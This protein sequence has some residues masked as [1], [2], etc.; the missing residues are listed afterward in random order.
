MF[1]LNILVTLK[2]NKT[3]RTGGGETAV[4]EVKIHSPKQPKNNQ[5]IFLY[6]V[7]NEWSYLD[8]GEPEVILMQSCH[9][10]TAEQTKAH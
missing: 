5:N 3:E 9:V 1:P 8:I 7:Y 2:T 10:N 6:F 4:S